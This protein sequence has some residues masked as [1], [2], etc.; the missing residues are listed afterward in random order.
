MTIKSWTYIENRSV[1]ISATRRE[2][3]MI[4]G[5]TIRLA[6]ALEKILRAQL[7]TTVRA[8]KVLRMPRPSQSRHH[9][10]FR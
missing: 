10:H 4:I 3:V 9:L 7:L 1:A 6:V 5:F 8:D 2:E